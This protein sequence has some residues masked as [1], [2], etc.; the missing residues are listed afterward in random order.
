MALFLTEDDVSGLLTMDIALEA[1][2]E[3]FRQQAKGGATNSPRTR[4]GLPGGA[5][6]FMSAAAPGLGF[7]GLKT[8]G[9]VGGGQTR[10]YLQL[11][12]T[13]NGQLA[14]IIEASR[15]GQIRTGA[16][17]GVATK[18]MARIDATTVGI[19][20]AGYQARTQL[21]ALCRV[22]RITTARVFSR[23]PERRQ[24]FVEA[25]GPKLDTDVISVESA[26]ACVS[27]ADIVV[28]ITGASSPVLSGQWLKPGTHVNA[29]G[30]NHWMRREVDDE[31]VRRAAVVVADD[32]EQARA[33]CGDIIY[34]AE[35]GVIHWQQVH[36]LWEIVVGAVPG[37][38]N[39]EEITLFE[40]QG[41]A[42]EDIATGARVY[43]L[44]MERG[45]GVE[46]PV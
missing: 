17:S 12:S 13:E 31:T 4:I 9:I 40:S 18:Y 29:A 26:E 45:V 46:L 19:I 2:E 11:Y 24:Q 3:G 30:A 25:M 43:Q 6:N 21:E 34:P 10:F 7:M 5:F 35:R 39:A 28:T 22:R 33:E 44:A 16:A 37:R 8:Y 15:M 41:L 23:T 38:T 1:V 32:L 20:G 36:N 14:A 42:L 27:D